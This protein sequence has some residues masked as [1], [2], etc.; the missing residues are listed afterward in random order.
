VHFGLGAHTTVDLKV[1]LPDGRAATVTALQPD[2]YLQLD[3]LT[4]AIS[5]V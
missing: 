4:G 1:T 3:V 2:R 5:E